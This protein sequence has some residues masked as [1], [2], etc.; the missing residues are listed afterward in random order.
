MC[1][2]T[3]SFSQ[4]PQG[5]LVSPIRSGWKVTYELH[6][7][8]S[9]CSSRLPICMISERSS[10]FRSCLYNYWPKSELMISQQ[11]AMHKRDCFVERFF[12]GVL[13]SEISLANALVDISRSSQRQTIWLEM[14]SAELTFT[15]SFICDDPRACEPDPGW[16]SCFYKHR[17][18]VTGHETRG[19]ATC[20]RYLVVIL[21]TIC[22][23]I[24]IN[25]LQKCWS[26]RTAKLWKKTLY[27]HVGIFKVKNTN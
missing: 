16:L 13:S 27:E 11:W 3:E 25:T 26:N 19:G 24:F 8:N 23:R 6:T 17:K 22:I 4:S 5:Q 15:C 14:T 7:Q 1:S 12:P 10:G 2:E 21:D 20:Q 18:T 9:S